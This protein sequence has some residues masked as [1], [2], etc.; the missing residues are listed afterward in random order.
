MLEVLDAKGKQNQAKTREKQK[1]QK[2]QMLEQ[3]WF[4]I[5]VFNDLFNHLIM[6]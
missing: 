1:G 5:F 2:E 6:F 3:W 4:S